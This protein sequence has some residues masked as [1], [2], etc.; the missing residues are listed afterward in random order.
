MTFHSAVD[1]KTA[2]ISREVQRAQSLLDEGKHEEAREVLG[3]ALAR[4]RALGRGS[5]H[6]HWMLA[7]ASDYLQDAQAAV[8]HIREAVSLDPGAPPFWR[9]LEIIRDRLLATLHSEPLGE[10]APNPVEL[11]ESLKSLGP[12]DAATHLVVARHYA[13]KGNR[14]MAVELARAVAMVTGDEAAAGLAE[15]LENAA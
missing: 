9:S 13:A 1:P 4:T 10:D 2:S 11:Y 15:E 7:I 6:I 3:R 8:H 5:A 12:V 14:K